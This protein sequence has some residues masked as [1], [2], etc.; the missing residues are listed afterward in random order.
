MSAGLNINIARVHT[1]LDRN[2]VSLEKS[3]NSIE[4]VLNVFVLNSKN[5]TV[6]HTTLL[7][8]PDQCSQV[9]VLEED[10]GL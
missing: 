8:V 3:L 1:S 10:V 6:G 9:S 7:H 5:F 4:R 2:P